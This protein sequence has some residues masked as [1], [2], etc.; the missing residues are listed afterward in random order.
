M[1]NLALWVSMF[2][3][4][5]PTLTIN[6]EPYS[7][8]C[9]IALEKIETARTALVPFRRTMELARAREERASGESA[10]CLGVG[11]GGRET[12]LRCR[13]F[14][15]QL[16]PPTNDDVAEAERYRQ[17]RKAFEDLFIQAKRICLREP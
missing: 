7:S 5:G 4:L 11:R 14:Q 6:A 13:R 3:L 2:L 1:K 16:P 8:T 17:K 9:E 15:W 12:P 10:A